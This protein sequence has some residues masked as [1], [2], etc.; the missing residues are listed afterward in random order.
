MQN[1]HKIS[2]ERRNTY[3]HQFQCTYERVNVVVWLTWKNVNLSFKTICRLLL[4]H[5]GF[6]SFCLMQWKHHKIVQKRD[7]SPLCHWLVFP[8]I[9]QIYCTN[10]P[11]CLLY[12]YLFT[13]GASCL[14]SHLFCLL[15]SYESHFVCSLI[16]SLVYFCSNCS[17]S[18]INNGLLP[19]QTSWIE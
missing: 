14:F 3:S 16:A 6:T 7:T 8:S 4:L 15:V 13:I 11:M 5:R 1:L 9:F 17:N 10:T 2:T 18:K 12:S 19:W